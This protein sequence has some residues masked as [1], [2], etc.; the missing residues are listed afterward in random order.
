M[1]D[2]KKII[3]IVLAA[4]LF[5]ALPVLVGT[6][7]TSC[8]VKLPGVVREYFTAESIPEFASHLSAFTGITW[9]IF[10]KVNVAW[11]FYDGIDSDSLGGFILDILL[12]GLR[13]VIIDGGPGGTFSI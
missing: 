9:A 10:S 6:L 12:H 3:L 7:S 8:G 5:A 4:V 13:D 11:R 1:L 2:I